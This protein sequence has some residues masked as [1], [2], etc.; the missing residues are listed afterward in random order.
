MI[1][2]GDNNIMCCTPCQLIRLTS[3]PLSFFLERPPTQPTRYTCSYVQDPQAVNTPAYRMSYRAHTNLSA[4][5]MQLFPGKY[6]I[7]YGDLRVCIY[8]LSAL[9]QHFWT[10][11]KGGAGSAKSC[12]VSNSAVWP[13]ASHV[14]LKLTH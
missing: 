5:G 7:I 3:N 14:E 8:H 12:M 13:R 11:C 9:K 10:N 4:L 2:G 1:S 6:T